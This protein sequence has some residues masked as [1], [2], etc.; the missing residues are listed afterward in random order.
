[1]ISRQLIREYVHALASQLG[2]LDKA[3]AEEVLREIESHIHDVVDQA[4]ARGEDFD[5]AALLAGFGPPSA[6]AA[7]YVAHIQDG[8]APPQGFRVIQ[9]VKQSVT[10]GLYY[11]MAAFGFP[12]SIAFLVL[13]LAKLF[14]P[15]SVGIWSWAEN[16]G[17]HLAITWSGSPDPRARELLGY[18]LVPIALFAAAW[19]AELTR[20]VLRVLR[21]GLR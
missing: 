17:D 18:G 9:R 11:S 1:M 6:L 20:R 10:R 14:D 4:E 13:A 7:Q 15:S 19:C 16:G 3:D 21:R 2:K 8:A 12:V 5:V